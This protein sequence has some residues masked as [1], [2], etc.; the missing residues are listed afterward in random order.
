MLKKTHRNILIWAVVLFGIILLVDRFYWAQ[1]SQWREDQATNIWLGYT[2]GIGHMPV[3]L[4]SSENI[5]NP[6]GMLLLG[7]LLSALPNLLSVSFFLGVLQIIL[8]VIVGRKSSGGNWQYFLLATIPPLSSVI[9]R[10]TSVEFSNQYTIAL[11]NIFFLFWALR[12]LENASLWNLPPIIILILLAP[13]L[14][15]AG[16]VNAIVMTLLAIGMIAYKRPNMNRFWTVFI[17]I[18]LL[19]SFS[20]LL[21]WLPYFQNVSIKQI[22]GYNNTSINP[23]GIQAA[24]KHADPGILSLPAQALL[25]I[26]GKAY[27][28]QALFAFAAFLYMIVVVFLK[29]MSSYNDGLKTNLVLLRIVV[30]SGL[31][32]SLSYILSAW[33][34]GPNW[35]NNERPDQIVQF[36]PLFLFFIFLLPSTIMVGGWAEKTIRRVS[37]ISLMI[38]ATVNLL[39]GFMIIRDHLQY[40][41]NVLSEADI[42][43]PHKMQAVDFIATDWEKYSSSNFIPVDYDLGGNKWYWVP[44]FGRKLRAWY[45]APMTQGR[46]FDYEL[47]HN[48]GLTNQQE[49]KQFRTFGNGRYLVTYAF[50]DPPQIENGQITHTIFGRLRVSIVE[51]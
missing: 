23:A 11:I 4:M 15:L 20:L 37:Y 35:I 27:L 26:A 14:Y 5:P 9:L 22:I 33:L 46:S 8:L 3:G 39:C 16:I 6:N 36:L 19:I 21:T 40:G 38:F 7:F 50:E 12:Y 17:I 10:S 24:F 25:K 28:F 42:P 13:S 1:I 44:K 32:I 31:F 30:L 49:G 48:H 34:G 2:A 29:G 51:K 43:L 18:S 45:P 47:L 41:G